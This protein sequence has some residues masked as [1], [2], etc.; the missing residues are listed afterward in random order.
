MAKVL[1][2]NNPSPRPV[3]LSP[4]VRGSFVMFV[5][6]LSH[7][8]IRWK[9]KNLRSHRGAQIP[10]TKPPWRLNFVRWRLTFV[11][12]QYGI[13][14]MSPFYQVAARFLENI[15]VHEFTCSW[16]MLLTKNCFFCSTLYHPQKTGIFTFI[17]VGISDLAWCLL[18]ENKIIIKEKEY[19]FFNK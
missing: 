18:H 6:F 5:L 7:S 13:C 3:D 11:A 4:C 8:R 1:E 2:A 9:T 15:R 16:I 19:D 14:F 17:A 12:V 10:D